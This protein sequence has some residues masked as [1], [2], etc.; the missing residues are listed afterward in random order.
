MHQYT[1]KNLKIARLKH[2]PVHLPNINIEHER[3]QDQFNR[4]EQDSLVTITSMAAILP[5]NLTWQIKKFNKI[6]AITQ[7]TYLKHQDP[8][9]VPKLTNFRDKNNSFQVTKV[10]VLIP[11]LRQK[12]HFSSTNFG[13]K[14]LL[15]MLK[16]KLHRP[17][18]SSLTFLLYSSTKTKII[19]TNEKEFNAS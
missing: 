9:H 15:Q 3:C 2:K 16:Y 12:Q 19:V 14:F 6:V 11:L 10:V 1:K 18:L 5:S 17:S 13:V 8:N 7:Y 4:K